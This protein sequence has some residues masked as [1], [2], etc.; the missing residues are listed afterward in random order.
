MEFSGHHKNKQAAYNYPL[1]KIY[2]LY[3]QQVYYNIELIQ[4]VLGFR[5]FQAYLFLNCKQNHWYPTVDGRNPKQPP[6]M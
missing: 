2:H 6:G 4:G 5:A 1:D 3:K